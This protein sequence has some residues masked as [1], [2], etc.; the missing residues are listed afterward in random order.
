MRVTLRVSSSNETWDGDCEFALVEVTPGLTALA[1]RRITALRAYKSADP[2][3]DET[4][5]WT[6]CV[7]CY[8]SPWITQEDAGAEVEA[9][10]LAAAE[11]LCEGQGENNEVVE[12]SDNFQVP[13]YQIAA[14][15]C[16]KMTVRHDAI[17]FSAIP[18]HTSFHIHTAEIPLA[19][20]E[21]AIV[22]PA[23]G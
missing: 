16:Q 23:R 4:Y 5:Y 14:V 11:R 20:L 17:A 15:E 2:D 6:S 1:L 18:K 12:V 19:M 8:F 9:A 7:E 13:S 3:I 21:A 22:P 10:C